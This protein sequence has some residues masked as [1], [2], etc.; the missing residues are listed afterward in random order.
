MC[1]VAPDPASSPRRAL[2]LT[3]VPRLRC[4]HVPHGSLRV[5]GHRNKERLSYNSMQQGLRI[6]K[7]RTRVT[8]APTRCADR[9]HHHDLQTLHTDATMS[10]YS[11]VPHG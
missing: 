1:H 5:V 4:L 8:E 7:T 11:D 9:R 3:H 6:S 2:T 10:C